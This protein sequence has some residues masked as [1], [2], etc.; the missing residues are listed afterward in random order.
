[1][2]DVTERE[3]HVDLAQRVKAA[4]VSRTR[5]RR[6]GPRSRRRATSPR[7][8]RRRARARRAHRTPA[9][10]REMCRAP[11]DEPVRRQTSGGGI[12]AN[13]TSRTRGSHG[14]TTSSPCVASNCAS[15]GGAVGRRRS[16]GRG[17]RW[18]TAPCDPRPAM[19]SS[20]GER[21]ARAPGS[22][23]PSS[24]ASASANRRSFTALAP[25]GPTRG[26]RTAARRRASSP[27]IHARRDR[28]PR[29]PR[30]RRRRRAVRGARAARRTARRVRRLWPATRGRP[31]A[32]RHRGWRG[33][34][35]GI[36]AARRSAASARSRRARR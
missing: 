12:A 11:T 4:G 29:A 24:S 34:T 19:S 27:G 8:R 25:A 2:R 15:S 33:S 14:S 28:P 31:S 6:T 3:P 21:I 35:N 32:P 1:M 26:R 20:P 16:S 18:S 17:P 13:A 9:R 36:I 23:Q 30:S 5:R 10:C 22:A 7:R